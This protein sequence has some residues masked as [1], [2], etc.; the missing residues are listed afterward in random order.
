MGLHIAF[1]LLPGLFAVPDGLENRGV[2]AG[3]T[4]FILFNGGVALVMASAVNRRLCD[5]VG[6]SPAARCWAFPR[7]ISGSASP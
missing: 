5:R 2:T 1:I 4:F 6:E 7:S 3:T